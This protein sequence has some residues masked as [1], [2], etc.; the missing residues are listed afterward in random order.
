MAKITFDLH[1]GDW[2]KEAAVRNLPLAARAIWVEMLLAM[3]QSDPE[4]YLVNADGSPWSELQIARY[5]SCTPGEV[6][7]ALIEMEK[8]GTFSRTEEGVIFSRRIVRRAEISGKRSAAGARGGNPILLKQTVKQTSNKKKSFA[9]PIGCVENG[10]RKSEKKASSE[11]REVDSDWTDADEWQIRLRR[12]VNSA[13]VWTGIEVGLTAALEAATGSTDPRRVAELIE[14]AL[15]A[16]T[17]YYAS[18][19]GS[20]NLRGWVQDGEYM[21]PPPARDGRG[22]G[23]T[24]RQAAEGYIRDLTAKGEL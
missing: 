14:A 11:L 8:L 18:F 4:G 12:A 2:Q 9:S 19:G 1:I 10:D 3:T 21:N 16:W 22:P 23:G 5:A 7:R 17:A 6:R 15:A 24:N 20:R 13:K